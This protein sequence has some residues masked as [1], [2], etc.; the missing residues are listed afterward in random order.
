V[1]LTAFLR[2]SE[3]NATAYRTRVNTLTMGKTALDPKA[4]RRH[5]LVVEDEPL[6]RDLLAK[7]I[8]AAGFDV[9]TA[10]NA[11]D[12]KRVLKVSDP[13]ALVL[14]IELGPGPNGLDLAEVVSRQYPAIGVV[15]LT[16]LPDPRFTLNPKS[17]AKNHAYLRK[18]VINSGNELLEVI[19]AVLRDRVTKEYRHDLASNRPL[20]QLSQRQLATLQMVSEGK[21]NSQIASL[22]GTTVRAVESMLSRIFEAM[23]IDPAS[24]NPRV[25]AVS[26]LHSSRVAAK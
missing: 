4:L 1:K 17:I 2:L 11:A 23:G 13:D 24:S 8:E 15:F 19:E 6:L 9:S 3:K 25:E 16:N 7:S 21:T 26:R 10:A 14:D 12:A 5:I 22:R 18:G 20:A